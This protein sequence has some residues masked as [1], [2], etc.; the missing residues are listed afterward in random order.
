MV[1]IRSRLEW[2]ESVRTRTGKRPR[3]GAQSTAQK[4]Q[5]PSTVNRRTRND[6]T[7]QSLQSIMETEQDVVSS[8][9]E[10]TNETL[11]VSLL[12][13]ESHLAIN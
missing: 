10:D 8:R 7:V 4:R 2:E 3:R 6:T 9:R 1:K 5:H 13:L 11:P 12:Y